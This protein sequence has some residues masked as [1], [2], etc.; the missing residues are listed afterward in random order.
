MKTNT[1]VTAKHVVVDDKTGEIRRNLV[2]Q[3]YEKITLPLTL[4]ATHNRNDIAILKVEGV[5]PCTRPLMPSHESL[6]GAKGMFYAGYSPSL[7][8]DGSDNKCQ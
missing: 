6:V 3:F 5:C 7:S 2:G 4:L 1:I 8:A